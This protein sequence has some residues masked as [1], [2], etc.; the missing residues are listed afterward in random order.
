M[1][2][3]CMNYIYLRIGQLFPSSESMEGTTPIDF[4]FLTPRIMISNTFVNIS[5]HGL[6]R[7]LG[8]ALLLLLLSS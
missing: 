5:V 6:L 2:Y 7:Y 4:Y 1:G 3:S 8:F